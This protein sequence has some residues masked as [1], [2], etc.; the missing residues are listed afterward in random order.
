MGFDIGSKLTNKQTRKTFNVMKACNEITNNEISNSLKDCWADRGVLQKKKKT[1]Q[2]S[3]KHTKMPWTRPTNCDWW[4][5]IWKNKLI[6]R[7]FLA[8]HTVQWNNIV[9]ILIQIVI[10]RTYTVS[11]L[12]KWNVSYHIYWFNMGLFK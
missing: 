1:I 6:N 2:K 3:Y 8:L 11:F 9:F 4:N 5:F 12:L 7:Y 10:P